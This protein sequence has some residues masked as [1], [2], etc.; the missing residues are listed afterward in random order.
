MPTIE[1]TLRDDQ[2]LL[3]SATLAIARA[4][5]NLFLTSL[6]VLIGSVSVAMAATDVFIDDKWEANEL[7]EDFKQYVTDYIVGPATISHSETITVT[8][9]LQA[10]STLTKNF[11]ALTF[12]GSY[13]QSYATTNTYTPTVPAGVTARM[14]YVPNMHHM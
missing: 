3:S 4:A 1:L 5:R 8:W 10:S 12:G 11:F 13:G 6:V 2:G 9:V 7:R 14:V